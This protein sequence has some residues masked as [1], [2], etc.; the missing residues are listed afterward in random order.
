MRCSN[1]GSE[2][3]TGSRFCIQCGAPFGQTCPKCAVENARDARFCS[4]CGASLEPILERHAKS[5]ARERGLAGERRHLTVLFCDLV[6]STEIA[7]RLDP[8]EWRETI[9][10]YHRAAA[11]A[12]TRYDGHVAQYLGDGVMAFFGYPEAHDNDA[13][14][15]VRAGLE[16]L[17]AIAKLGGQSGR[18]KLAARVGIDSGA[19][20]VGA[21][22]GKDTDVFGEAPNIAAR[23]QAVAEPGTV[24]ITDTVHRLVPG[25]FVV[26]SRGAPA[27]KGIERPLQLYKIVQPS[28]V[29]GRL[30]ATAAVRG[31]TPFVGREDELRL[32]MNRW[33]HALEG[34]GQ[35]VLV[36]GEAG[37]GKSR[38]LH[39]FY[40]LT[41]DVSHAWIEAA[42]APFFQN[43]P[44]HAITQLLR[45]LVGQVSLPA[46]DVRAARATAGDGE[47]QLDTNERLA[48]VESALVLAGLKPAEAIPLIAP[49]LNLP[50]SAKYP[51]P[52]IPPEQQRRRLLAML[53]EWVLGAA[54]Y[55]P[56]VIVIEDLHWADASTLE[57]IQL[58]AEQGA[59]TRLLLLCTA[60]PDFRP[61]WPLRAHHTQITLNRLSAS[62]VRE[63]IARVAARH[64]LAGETVETVIERTGG[65]PLFVEELTR[66]V[67]ESDGA[68]LV[69][70]E[71]PVTLHDSLMARLDRL[72]SA[73]EVIQIGAVIGGEF[74]YE[75]LHAIHPVGEEELQSALRSATGAELVYVHGIAPEATYQFKHALIRD[76]AYEALLKSRRRELHR[77][78]ANLIAERLPQTATEHPEVLA[79]HWTGAGELEKALTA[80]SSAGRIARKRRAFREAERAYQHALEIISRLPESPERDAL[81]L[82]VVGA[83]AQVKELTHGYAAAETKTALSRALALVRRMGNV[84]QLSLQLIGT[85]AAAINSGDYRS[86]DAL[87]RESIELAEREG[88]AMNLAFAHMARIETHF[89]LGELAEAENRFMG[90][91]AFFDEQGFKQ[92]PGALGTVLAFAGLTAFSGGRIATALTRINEASRAAHQTNNP[93]DLAFTSYQSGTLKLLVGEPAGAVIVER[94]AVNLSEEYGFPHIAA[95]ARTALGA[96]LANCGEAGHGA[97]LIEEGMNAAAAIE[98]RMN[99]TLS[100]FYLAQAQALQGAIDK[101]L[102][103]IERAL[104]ANPDEL[105]YRPEVLRLRGEFRLTVGDR[106]QAVADFGEAIACAH[107]MGAK[108]FELRAALSS[109]RLMLTSD[110]RV[111]ARELLTPIY[112]GFA[113][114]LDSRDLIQARLLLEEMGA[115]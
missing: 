64:A 67:L 68:K 99:V 4:Q 69:G 36:I 16:L 14:R 73:K 18:A 58:L 112:D 105:I 33:E 79:R 27:L 35:V 40:E 75:L 26:E 61:Q 70:R 5:Q 30:E 83:L 39:R 104:E 29:R 77:R 47:A 45:Q 103:S 101:A 41:P 46:T 91:L 57:V 28:G 2:N 54:R 113:E 90:G 107:G 89:Y 74:S 55:Q 60:R 22:A 102:Y 12:V 96:A 49:L 78:T 110:D 9:A 88:N 19:V 86:A 93:Y 31:L 23:V 44:F 7:A 51:A 56:S 65:V 20:V 11:E 53:V 24:L 98:T 81:E 6:G 10:A 25:L 84:G 82:P 37:I 85:W 106:E 80:W 100:L 71:I 114:G 66:A 72:G 13:E 42:V 111:G 87:S 38:L 17:D 8:E 97:Q 50:L 32:L 52:P 94:E 21:G 3:L 109:A 43:T 48:Q 59:T 95:A 108:S 63:M 34:E 15:A 92:F 76:A 1:C 115:S 62:N